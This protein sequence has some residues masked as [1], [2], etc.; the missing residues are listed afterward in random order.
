M[1][2]GTGH[3]Y[4]FGICVYEVRLLEVER[5]QGNNDI[6]IWN[7]SQ[8][9]RAGMVLASFNSFLTAPVRQRHEAY[10]TAMNLADS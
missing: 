1:R 2:R 4:I 9:K 7:E 10:K 8:T 5:L 6:V 3:I